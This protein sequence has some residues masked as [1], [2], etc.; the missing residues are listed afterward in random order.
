MSLPLRWRVGLAYSILIAFAI[1][2]LGYSLSN[3]FY[4]NY[5]EYIQNRLLSEASVI[6]RQA[7]AVFSESPPFP[8]GNTLARAHSELLDARITFI[9]PDGTVIV[10]TESKLALSEN[11]AD[12]P[13]VIQALNSTPFTDI[14]HS[15]TIQTDMLYAAAPVMNGEKVTGVV[16]LAI[17]LDRIN[18][19]MAAIRRIILVGTS[20]VTVISILLAWILS[21]YITLPLRKLTDTVISISR[22]ETKPGQTSTR[23]D[24]IGQLDQAFNQMASQLNSQ[25]DALQTERGKLSAVLANMA[26]GILIVD[27]QGKVQLINQ[28]AQRI[29]NIS[30][31]N[32]IG[33]SLI[34]VV[35][36]HQ[37]VDLWRKCQTSGE[38]QVHMLET[39]VERLFLQGIA[40]PLD[41]AMPGGILM[42]FQDLT[43]VRRLENIRRDFVSNV[44]HE[45][46]TP[47]A[48]LKA[49]AETLME[50]ALDDP[51]AARRFL[52]RMDGEIDNLTQM[53]QELLELSRIESGRV[54]LERANMR[55]YDLLQP[56]C[57]RMQLQVQRAGLRLFLECPL[58][59]PLIHVDSTRLAQVLVNLLHNAVKFTPPGGEIHAGAYQQIG[60]VIFFVRDTGVGIKPDALPRIFERFYKADRSRSG[61]GTG[62][63]LSISRHMVEAHGGRI[64][65]ESTPE[66]GSTFYF[67]L[68]QA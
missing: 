1:G 10:D 60:N 30:E 68:P 51:P 25:I 5:I 49:I 33:N 62:L 50:G 27:A 7:I 28:A 47:L 39:S 48:S 52:D 67:S 9:L 59:L 40:T 22:G 42:V 53:V 23:N 31:I 16:R 11:H 45:L 32:A 44:S 66:K 35:R 64:W 38:Q 6:A 37:L 13:E 19:D 58:D 14:R 18:Q 15:E 55:P 29:F 17:S 20:V 26:D 63:G 4:Q 24:E 2:G 12:R 41:Q 65:A 36:Q 54:P 43:R 46:R 34:E 61:G 57:D 21:A 8:S 3:L 56:A